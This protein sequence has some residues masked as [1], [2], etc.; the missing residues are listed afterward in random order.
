MV[1]VALAEYGLL[2]FIKCRQGISIS[3]IDHKTGGSEDIRNPTSV[4]AYTADNAGNIQGENVTN[5]EIPNAWGTD[6]KSFEKD[7][8]AEL[9]VGDLGLKR[10]DFT[11]FVIFPITFL[12]FIIVYWCFF[13]G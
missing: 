3:K 4:K 8:A 9:D 11:S 13:K 10:I 2:L 12:L 1:F 5:L 7:L 6:R